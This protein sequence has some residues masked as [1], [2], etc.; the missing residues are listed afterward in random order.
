MQES[1]LSLMQMAK[2]APPRQ[3]RRSGG[4]FI[5]LFADPPPRCHRQLR[6]LAIIIAEPKR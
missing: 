1:T 5:S 4:L 3:T 2:T 6:V